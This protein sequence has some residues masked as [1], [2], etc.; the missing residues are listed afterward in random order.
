M[1]LS[2]LSFLFPRCPPN[3]WPSFSSSP[4]HFVYHGFAQ[5]VLLIILAQ[6]VVQFL[7]SPLKISVE[8]MDRMTIPKYGY[9]RRGIQV[10]KTNQTCE[11]SKKKEKRKNN[12]WYSSS[13]QRERVVLLNTGLGYWEVID[14]L[15]NHINTAH[16]ALWAFYLEP[17]MCIFRNLTDHRLPYIIVVLLNLPLQT[18]IFFYQYDYSAFNYHW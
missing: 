13:I 18:H 1:P 6:N 16:T 3:T 10:Q 4:G 2:C 8:S 11:P 17:G 7:F 5:V 12:N 15:R 14:N 9:V